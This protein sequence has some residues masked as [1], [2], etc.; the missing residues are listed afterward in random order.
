MVSQTGSPHARSQPPSEGADNNEND[1]IR[2]FYLLD[3]A[4]ARRP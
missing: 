3:G 4:T 1:Q 2:L